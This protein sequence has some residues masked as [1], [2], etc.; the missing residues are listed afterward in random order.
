[1]V[2]AMIIGAFADEPVGLGEVVQFDGWANVSWGMDIDSGDTGFTNSTSLNFTYNLFSTGSKN[3]EGFGV[4]GDLGIVIQ[5][6]PARSYN[7]GVASGT[8]LAGIAM[9]QIA[10]DHAKI[11]FGDMF[12]TSVFHD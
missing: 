6:D 5:Y 7:S 4:W 2:L 10:V 8:G 11:H 3:T 1:M 12:Y 9:P